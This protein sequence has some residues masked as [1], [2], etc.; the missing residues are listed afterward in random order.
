MGGVKGAVGE[1]GKGLPTGDYTGES[2]TR[3]G[4]LNWRKGGHTGARDS[5]ASAD[6]RTLN[7]SASS[8]VMTSEMASNAASRGE[9]WVRFF[10]HP[11]SSFAGT[12]AGGQESFPLSAA[13]L[14]KIA[15][16]QKA[17][18]KPNASPLPSY[19]RSL[20]SFDGVICHIGVGGFHRS[21]MAVYTHQRLMS[22]MT[23]GFNGNRERWGI[24]GIGIM[25]WDKEMGNVLKKQDNMYTVLG[26]DHER[27]S[28]TVVG[29][30]VG[31]V[32]P[33]AATE[34]NVLER[35]AS[36]QT[37][38][39]SLTITEKGYCLDVNHAL[40]L[41]NPLVKHDLEKPDEVCQSAVGTIVKALELRFDRGMNP[42]TVMSCDNLPGNGHITEHMVRGFLLAKGRDD[43]TDWVEANCTFPNTMVDRITPATRPLIP[44]RPHPFSDTIRTLVRD[45]CAV[46]DEWP[47]IAEGYMQWV[48]EDKFLYGRPA[49][50]KEGALFVSDVGPYEA[51]KLRL[52]NAGHSAISYSSY[53]MGHRYVDTAMDSQS[54]QP[55]S[56]PV[57]DFCVRFFQ[58][59]SPN[60][61][62]VPGVDLDDYKQTLL[63]R[64]GYVPR[65]IYYKYMYHIW[66]NVFLFLIH[67]FY[68][69]II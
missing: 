20:S 52:L 29:S 43:L 9:N 35:L 51:M 68:D 19:A 7:V 18:M 25:P 2:G 60:V 6:P 62:P 30:I 64:F 58:E 44:D 39:V 28:G 23:P 69:V 27:T 15:K 26:R 3:K 33:D 36:A 17:A 16:A 66:C 13:N 8:S 10:L 53:L 46:D 63:K 48:I 22:Q 32:G 49:W 45:T 55:R 54:L 57:P 12:I 11:D 38:I 34:N 31:F 65:Y 37:K 67:L 61:P 47:V 24:I 41:N 4:N 59:Q 40:D 50:E 14:P 5:G 42:F 21:H 1:A 56:N